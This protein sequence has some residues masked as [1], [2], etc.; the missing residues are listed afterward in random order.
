MKTNSTSI[1]LFFC[2]CCLI[3]CNKNMP[4]SGKVTFAD[5]NTPVPCGMIYFDNGQ[6]V[7]RGNIQPDGNYTIGFEKTA[8]GIPAGEYKVYFSNVVEAVEN[9]AANNITKISS[10]GDGASIRPLIDKKYDQAETTDIHFKFDGSTNKF[11]IKLAR[12]KN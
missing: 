8:N 2:V 6:Q 10:F 3:G 7:G 5:D 11:D 4:L 12:I 9:K 1:A